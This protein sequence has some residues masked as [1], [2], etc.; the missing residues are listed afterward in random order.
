MVKYFNNKILTSFNSF[1]LSLDFLGPGPEFNIQKQ[2]RYTTL[3]GTIFSF[4]S[5]FLSFLTIRFSIIN[6]FSR[7]NP[8]TFINLEYENEMLSFERNQ[9]K[10]FITVMYQQNL[11]LIPIKISDVHPPEI[12]SFEISS[13]GLK[14][15]PHGNLINCNDDFF[16]DYNS[17]SLSNE[18]YSDTYIDS[19]KESAFCLP[20]NLNVTI[21]NELRTSSQLIMSF[22]FEQYEKLINKYKTI[23]IRISYTSIMLFPNNFEHYYKKIWNEFMV[24]VDIKKLLR[25]TIDIEKYKISK[26]ETVFLFQSIKEITE[27]NTKGIIQENSL[28]QNRIKGLDNVVM[29]SLKKNLLNSSVL[30]KYTSID[31]ILSN[32]GGSFEIIKSVCEVIVG[33][34]VKNLYYPYLMNRIFLF[35]DQPC[36]Y[37]KQ[38]KND[39]NNMHLNSLIKNNSLTDRTN[40][41]K[42]F[43]NRNRNSNCISQKTVI[44]NNENKGKRFIIYNFKIFYLKMKCIKVEMV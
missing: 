27:V 2:S 30:I 41:R 1:L 10:F 31:T 34:I 39:R 7:S 4:L 26:D 36:K 32:F 15:V 24:G 20:S 35:Y 13:T 29:I 33:V 22:P 5:F 9:N 11:N 17:G 25:Y 6:F 16:S 3:I 12:S 42:D 40:L 43:I 28:E 18:N 23:L 44:S 14:R 8:D 38:S 19:L 21:S 37:R